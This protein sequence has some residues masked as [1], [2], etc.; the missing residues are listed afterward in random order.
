M[1]L[2]DNEAELAFVLGHEVGHI[3]ARHAQ[4]RQQ[5]TRRN[6]ILGVLGAI[7]GSVVGSN[8]FGELLTRGAMQAAQYATLSFSREQEYQADSLGTRYIVA[9]GYNPIGG[10]GVLAA[11]TRASALEAR[12]QGRDSRQLPGDVDVTAR[13]GESVLDGRVEDGEVIGVLRDTRLRGYSPADGVDVIGARAGLG[14]A[15][16]LHQFR[17]LL[18]RLRDIALVE[19]SSAK[20]RA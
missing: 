3:A 16:L 12:I 13:H 19:R 10:P 9:A 20:L 15:E 11:L 17:M 18:D 1:T 6:T 5:A 4:A 14:A 8:I 7:L 2:M